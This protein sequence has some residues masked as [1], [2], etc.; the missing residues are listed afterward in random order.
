VPALIVV[1]FLGWVVLHRRFQGPGRAAFMRFR[2]RV[3]PPATLVL[4][5]LTLA[6]PAMY[7]LSQASIEAK[8][9]PIALN[10]AALAVLVAGWTLPA[11]VPVRSATTA[12]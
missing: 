5:A 9:L 11:A 12:V 8:V 2:A 6:G 7:V 3:W 4:V 1:A 10:A